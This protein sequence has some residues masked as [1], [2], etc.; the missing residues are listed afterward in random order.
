MKKELC[1]NSRI[2]KN[3]YACVY[4]RVR[5]EGAREHTDI[6]H[7]DPANPRLYLKKCNCTRFP[8][9][10]NKT[11]NLVYVNKSLLRVARHHH[12]KRAH[13]CVAARQAADVQAKMLLTP[14][15]MNHGAKYLST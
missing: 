5:P 6:T 11:Q 2:T 7:S 8:R 13:I 4:M 9:P 14:H 1:A 12:C 15:D 3:E 10:G